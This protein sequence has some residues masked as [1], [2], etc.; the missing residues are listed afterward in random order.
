MALNEALG[1]PR[2]VE[3]R[4]GRIRYRDTGGDGPVVVLVHGA[5]VNADLW[6][7]VVPPLA[8]AG[9]RCLAPDWPF[10][11][12]EVAVPGMSL[13]PPGI[14]SLLGEFL[15]Q[16]DLDEVTLVANDTGGAFVQVFLATNPSRVARVVLTPSDSFEVFFPRRF[17]YLPVLA[18]LPGALWLMLR[19]AGI[20]PAIQ[21]LP[22]G[23]SALTKHGIDS[24]TVLSWVG[25]SGR[26]RAVRADLRRFL[27][28]IDRRHTLAAA[29]A[30]RGFARP[31]LLAWAYEDRLIPITLAHRLAECLPDARVV[32]IPDS[33]TFVPL[34]Q[35]DRLAREIVAFLREDRARPA[36]AAQPRT[37][38]ED[39]SAER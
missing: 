2:E 7:A 23:I 8:A 11:A 13:D 25:P 21:R 4:G 18:R 3:L 38:V 17:A 28:G 35:P 10:G 22:F 27:R 24:A 1:Q 5:L 39:A 20:W 33:H 29:A 15:E 34:D 37:G 6:R 30:L 16:L 31:V 36:L 32:G 14:A 19:L 9:M 12:H 26:D